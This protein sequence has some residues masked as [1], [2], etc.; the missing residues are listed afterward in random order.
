MKRYHDLNAFEKSILEDK[1]TE[2]PFTGELDNVFEAG[3]YVCK[4]C[5]NPL[6]LSSSK[7]NAGCG[8]PSFESDLLNHVDTHPDPD[9]KRIEIVCSKCHGHLGHV[10]KG[11][12]L[13]PKNTRHC[14]NST[15]L[16]FIPAFTSEGY[17]TAIVAGG[18][19]WGVEHLLKQEQ[20]VID[21]TSGYL[22]GHVTSPTYEEVCS[23]LTAHVEACQVIF[24]PEKTTYENILKAFFEIHDFT[25]TNGQGPDL[26]SQYLSKIFVFSEKQEK[27]A[28]K[29]INQLTQ[30][31][32]QV[33]TEVLPATTFYKAEKYHQNYY[34][35]T[36]KSPY[37]HIKRKIFSTLL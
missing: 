12:K 4:K 7:F 8:W 24:D 37:C 27:I 11:E 3:V 21:V 34:K 25:Q 1:K 16:R 5:D 6:Y 14:V 2:K 13:T 31:G 36:G 15:S 30:K 17:E 35:K 26:G 20:G 23:G 18:C 19:F 32:Y 9:G 29:L 22:G 33:A 10:F 28:H